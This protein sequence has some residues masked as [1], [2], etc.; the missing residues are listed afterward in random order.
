M[1]FFQ[2]HAGN[3]V[4]FNIHSFTEVSRL[5]T[6]V[7]ALVRLVNYLS[8]NEGCFSMGS[9]IVMVFF[10]HLFSVD[11]YYGIVTTPR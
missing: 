5:W 9:S 7:T 3:A 1:R 8:F 6:G 11:S 10:N 4:Q 2:V